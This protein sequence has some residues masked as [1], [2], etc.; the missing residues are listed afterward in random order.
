MDNIATNVELL[1]EKAK[2]YT[3][4][5]L[6][7]YKLNAIDKTADVVSSLI[8]RIALLLFVAMFTLFVNIALSLY[9]GKL[10]GEYYYGFLVVSGFYFILSILLYFYS[11]KY[12]KIPVTN[13]VIAK[14]LKTKIVKSNTKITDDES[15]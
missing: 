9:L 8:S 10:L 4:T 1:F 5:S 2:N 13:L 12:I 15:L 6:E 14:L 11:N 3:E 7:L